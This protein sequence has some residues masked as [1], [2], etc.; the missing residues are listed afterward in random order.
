MEIMWLGG[1]CFRLR[2]RDAAVVTDPFTSSITQKSA[3]PK[4]DIVTLSRLPGGNLAE[5][6]VRPNHE[7]RKPFVIEGPGEYEV[8]G[9]HVRSTEHHTLPSA[10]RATIYAI[11]I[12]G[13]TVGYVPPLAAE[14][15]DAMLDELGT[16]HVLLA[17]TAGDD[18]GLDAAGLLHLITRVEPNIVVPFSSGELAG[19]TAQSRWERVLR[20]LS[21]APVGAEASLTV[22]RQSLPEPVTVKA[23]SARAK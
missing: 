22:S 14:P 17:D 10:R 16:V 4:A 20:E 21:G 18:S 6:G 13:L 7:D 15:T 19:G 9:V 8:A 3:F 23:L 2:G 12:D 1:G 5:G 11:D